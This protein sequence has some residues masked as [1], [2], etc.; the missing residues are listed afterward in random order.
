MNDR[1]N[2]FEAWPYAS[3]HFGLYLQL[4]C[5]N[6]RRQPISQL[7]FIV[8]FLQLMV[9]PRKP[10]RI[11]DKFFTETRQAILET[12][13]TTVTSFKPTKSSLLSKCFLLYDGQ[14][15]ES[16]KAGRDRF[17]LELFQRRFFQKAMMQKKWRFSPKSGSQKLIW[18]KRPGRLSLKPGMAA[19]SALGRGLCSP[20][21]IDQNGK[22]QKSWFLKKSTPEY[23]SK[24]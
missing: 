4:G 13:K 17:L 9:L 10:T 21:N 12:W 2:L 16:K 15:E 6:L 14:L 23:S 5:S 20:E 1:L 19:W 24:L 7:T 3:I 11:V 22:S 8:L 18:L